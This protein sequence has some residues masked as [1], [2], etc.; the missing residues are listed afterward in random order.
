[1]QTLRKLNPKWFFLL[2]IGGPLLTSCTDDKYDLKSLDWTLGLGGNSLQLPMN[3]STNDMIL[4]DILDLGEGDLIT[5]DE[6]GNYLMS[7]KPDSTTPTDVHVNAINEGTPPQKTSADIPVPFSTQITNQDLAT[8]SFN[9]EVPNDVVSL[10]WLDTDM[11]ATLKLTIP[12]ALTISDFQIK[13]PSFLV[14]EATSSKA[15]YTFENNTIKYSSYAGSSEDLNITL[16][17]K[18]I[19]IQYIDANNYARIYNKQ[20]QIKGL[21]TLSGYINASTASTI[22]TYFTFNDTKLNISK[23]KGVFDPQINITSDNLG[24]V[25]INDIP[26]FLTD[27]DVTIDL[28]NI[29]ITLDITSSLPIGATLSGKLASDTYPTGISYTGDKAIRLLAATNGERNYK[30]LLCKK[31]PND[32]TPY[33]QVIVDENLTKLVYKI[34]EG[35]QIQFTEITAKADANE[36]EVELGKTYTINPNYSFEAPLAFG[37]NMRIVYSTTEGGMSKETSKMTL[38]DGTYVEMTGS[39]HNRVP[40]DL[41]LSFIFV[42]IDGNELPGM[43][44]D[45]AVIKGCKADGNEVVTDFK[46]IA[47]D[48]NGS[49][50][51]TEGFKLRA[52]GTTPE[53]ST[54]IPLNKQTQTLRIDNMSA[55]VIGKVIYDAN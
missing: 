33:D 7:K 22:G 25:T 54:G 41:T 16:K 17:F 31:V 9:Y 11:P 36:Y 6:N 47:R 42:D 44:V 12:A 32:V 43:L 24:K 38:M 45:H 14:M 8:F 23:V 48:T 53:N 40:I 15:G 20:L 26:D 28:E 34:R 1:M 51:K 3:N 13:F 49:F 55:K 35:M 18:R 30:I 52:E 4:D 2:L 39:A 50:K 27:E 21:I 5:T 29:Q 46:I 19:N 10:S 37:P